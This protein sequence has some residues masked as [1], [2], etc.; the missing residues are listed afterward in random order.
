MENKRIVE[1]NGVKLEIDLTTARVVDNYRV[2]DNVKVLVKQYGDSLKSFPG[3]IIGFDAF[4]KRPTIVIAY[5]DIEYSNA[6]VKFVYLNADTKDCEICPMQEHELS[7]DK[8]RV[9][10]LLDREITKREQE[11]IE[12]KNKKGYFL[13][14]FETYFVKEEAH[15]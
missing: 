14:H 9:V 12:V 5:L 11:L 10:D 3:V 6:S 15:S 4:E 8:S 2:G 1:I 7:F 13:S